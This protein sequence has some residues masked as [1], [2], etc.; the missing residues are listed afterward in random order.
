MAKIQ[1]D[2]YVKA[3]IKDHASI[4][5]VI[6]LVIVNVHIYNKVETYKHSIMCLD[7]GTLEKSSLLNKSCKWTVI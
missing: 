3:P 1:L 2:K 7:V 4:I 6:P 5:I